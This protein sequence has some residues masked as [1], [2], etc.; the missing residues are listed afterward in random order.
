MMVP[1]DES[2][3]GL[4]SDPSAQGPLSTSSVFR[5]IESLVSPTRPEPNPNH[6]VCD[7][8]TYRNFACGLLHNPGD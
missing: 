2:P 4:K 3:T 6:S 7:V 8:G 5:K 1:G